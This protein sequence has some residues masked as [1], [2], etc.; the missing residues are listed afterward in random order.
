MTNKIKLIFPVLALGL[1][2]SGTAFAATTSTTTE[3]KTEIKTGTTEP[4]ELKGNTIA[5]QTAKST[6]ITDAKTTKATAVK[7]ANDTA[8]QT[9]L[10]AK[11]VKDTAIKTAK[12]NTDKTAKAAAIK[13]ANDTYK[14][15]VNDAKS[16]QSASIKTATTVYKNAI[17]TCPVK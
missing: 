9:I 3:E 16:A 17:K 15:A 2:L 1:V 12:S 4:K 8:K 6:C 10:D 13:L 14:K 11:I 7:L 5:A